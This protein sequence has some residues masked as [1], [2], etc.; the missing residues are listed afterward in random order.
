M[1]REPSF[2]GSPKRRELKS[3]YFLFLYKLITCFLSNVGSFNSIGDDTL[4]SAKFFSLLFPNA[5]HMCLT[6][7]SQPLKTKSKH[8]TK[9]LTLNFTIT[10]KIEPRR[11]TPTS[12]STQVNEV[13]KYLRTQQQANRRGG[14]YIISNKYSIWCVGCVSMCRCRQF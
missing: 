1:T 11:Q 8:H 5:L 3:Y 13:F 10:M 4:Y 7:N 12:S 6:L 14:A 2:R 9:K